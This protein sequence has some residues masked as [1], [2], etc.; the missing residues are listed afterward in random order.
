MFD[1]IK[2]I[3]INRSFSTFWTFKNMFCSAQYQIVHTCKKCL[4]IKTRARWYLVKLLNTY[5]YVQTINYWPYQFS[6]AHLQHG[7]VH[8][9]FDQQI[10]RRVL[11]I[12]RRSGM[13]TVHPEDTVQ[14]SQDNA[15]FAGTEKVIY[16]QCVAPESLAPTTYRRPTVPDFEQRHPSDD[17]Y[18]N[19]I[20]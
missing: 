13:H 20:I 3:K 16:R 6:S 11:Q 14:T 4:K 1:S 19:N 8:L 5:S 10:G 2:T 15:V 9:H 7:T 17:N 18:N 12:G